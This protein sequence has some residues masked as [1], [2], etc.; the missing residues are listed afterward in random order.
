MPDREG[1]AS[2]AGVSWPSSGG[3][4]VRDNCSAIRMAP[5]AY[6]PE[7]LL[8]RPVSLLGAGGLVLEITPESAGWDL[9]SFQ[10]RRFSV[11]DEWHFST[12]EHE[13]ALVTLSGTYRV[14]ST[15]GAWED[16]GAREDVFRGIAHTLYL[17]RRV[18]GVVR[19]AVAGELAIAQAPVGR[20]G[21]PLFI[22]PD[23]VKISIRGGDN[24]TRQINYLIPPGAPVERLVVVEVYTPGGSWSS[25]PPHKH[26]VHRQNA[27]GEL[28]EADLEEVYFYKID[29]PH[30]YAL[31]HIYTDG[32][33]PLDRSGRPID[34]LIRVSNNEAVIV[35]EGYHPVVSPPG[36][37][38][39]YL[40]V[41]AGSA[42]SLA[43]SF[44]PRHAWIR[45]AY[46]SR[47]PRV[48]LYALPHQPTYET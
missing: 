47:D 3:V 29:K 17:P 11:G 18:E 1:R 31:Q 36:Y 5:Q 15:R 45:E 42:Q 4:V 43:C 7:T 33:S 34:A 37:T 20:D 21:E 32:G 12:G 23:D 40:N 14:E 27:E 9:I 8:V 24:A 41:L 28:V 35:P 25:F 6:T 38:T 10:V 39:Y 2:L 16:V 13:I 48:P 22:R 44:D 30:G 19:A 46:R 26:D